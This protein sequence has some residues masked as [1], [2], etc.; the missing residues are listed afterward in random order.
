MRTQALTSCL[1]WYR[2]ILQQS[3]IGKFKFPLKKMV[4]I[5]SNSFEQSFLGE[6][7]NKMK[8][9]YTPTTTLWN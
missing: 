3:L 7:N 2:I 5:G 8:I 4:G 6:D 1:G 9:K